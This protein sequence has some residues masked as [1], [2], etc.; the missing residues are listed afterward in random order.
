MTTFLSKK[1]NDYQNTHINYHTGNTY[2]QK[3]QEKSKMTEFFF[4]EEKQKTSKKKSNKRKKKS[5]Y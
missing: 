4:C 2:F 1:K 3:F 5:T